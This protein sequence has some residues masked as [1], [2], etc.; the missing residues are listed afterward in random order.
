VAEFQ[1]EIETQ[2][3]FVDNYTYEATH[4]FNANAFAETLKGEVGACVTRMVIFRHSVREVCKT[5]SGD[6][7]IFSRKLRENVDSLRDSAVNRSDLNLVC[8]HDNTHYITAIFSSLIFLKSFL[9]IYSA[10]I[11]KSIKPNQR[12]VF[13][14]GNVDGEKI[15]GGKF[16]NFLRNTAQAEY[17]DLSN[18]IL[19]HSQSWIHLAVRY[20]DE[21]VHN[22]DLPGLQ[23]MRI[24]LRPEDPPYSDK[25]IEPPK[26][27]NGVEVI[28]Y[29]LGLSKN[30]HRFVEETIPLIPNIDM[31]LVDF[32]EFPLGAD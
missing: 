9:D 21:L 4:I 12:I 31:G 11:A 7:D 17:I 10:L 25:D 19:R 14:K 5:V 32:R 22:G 3:I 18:I 8:C 28:E 27:P 15:A 2:I 16:I 26:M 24:S 29:V 6:L 23:R 13:R 1:D 30:I 20:R